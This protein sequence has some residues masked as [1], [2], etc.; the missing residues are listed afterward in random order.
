METFRFLQHSLPALALDFVR[1][2]A[3]LVILLVIFVPLEKAFA[4]RPQRVV[5]RSFFIDIGYYMINGLSLKL[6][7]ILPLSIVAGTLH[8]VAPGIAYFSW[9]ADQP[10]SL[11][12]FGAILVGEFGA[13]WG[14]RWAHE[15]PV[16][17][18]FH[19]I[20]HS[21]EEVD[22][23]VNTRA[24]PLDMVFM[25]LCGLVPVYALGLAQPT[26]NTPDLVPML[27]AL[28]GTIWSFFIH[29][30]VNWRMGWLENVI[31]TPGFHHWHHT[32]DGPTYVDKN[33]AAIFPWLDRLFGTFFLPKDAWPIRY[34]TDTAVATSLVGQILQ[35]FRTPI[36][37]L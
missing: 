30:N 37:P 34:G 28:T 14:H 29:A 13:Y 5:R 15:V 24:H 12:F 3:W 7:L 16:L 23:L 27:Y 17:W 18:R 2:F 19:A 20:H 10:F 21:A 33:Y 35:P 11:R 26:S 8:Y 4:R 32:N 6:L 22:W 1:L 25:R 31:S 36:P 9:V